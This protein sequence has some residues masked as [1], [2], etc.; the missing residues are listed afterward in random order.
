MLIFWKSETWKREAE[1]NNCPQ[2]H[3][4]ES[5]SVNLFHSFFYSFSIQLFYIV[6]ILVFLNCMNKE[7]SEITKYLR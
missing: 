3:Q 7:F 5:A 4:T 6:E 2:F 1:K